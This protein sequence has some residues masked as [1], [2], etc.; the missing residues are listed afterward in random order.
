[1]PARRRCR[2]TGRPG[3]TRISRGAI[4]RVRRCA[5]RA[6]EYRASAWRCCC[7]IRRSSPPRSMACWRRCRGGAA[8][9]AGARGRARAADRALR[10]AAGAGAMPLTWNSPALR[11]ALEGNGIALL[12]LDLV[13]A[14][15]GCEAVL[16]EPRRA[17][18]ARGRRQPRAETLACII[19]TSGTT[20]RPKGVMLSHG[21]LPSNARDHRRLPE[22]RARRQGDVPAAV[23]FFLW[24]VGAQQQP[25]CAARTSC[26]K[27]TWRFRRCW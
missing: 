14:A 27:T 19:Y 13:D 23:S 9:R 5:R 24:H 4:S 12:P 22:H 26:S 1:M 17:S 11:E 3:L 2:G 21:N 10:R 6:G 7:A 16:R 25:G 20:G 18:R 8:Q 15:N